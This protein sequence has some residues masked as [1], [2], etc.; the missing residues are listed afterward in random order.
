MQRTLWRGLC[1]VAALL[2]PLSVRALTPFPSVN[3]SLESYTAAQGYTPSVVVVIV[4]QDLA[5]RSIQGVN[6]PLSSGRAGLPK[7]TGTALFVNDGAWGASDWTCD[8]GKDSVRCSGAT[9]LAAGKKTCIALYL[10]GDFVPAAGISVGFLDGG[11][12]LL[13]TAGAE[14]QSNSTTLPGEVPASDRL[15]DAGASRPGSIS[16]PWLGGGILLA[17]GGVGFA[18]WSK[19]R[20]RRPQ[21][22]AFGVAIASVGA[23][24]FVYSF[25][26]QLL[27]FSWSCPLNCSPGSQQCRISYAVT[28]GTNSISTEQKNAEQ[29]ADMIESL[30]LLEL[31]FNAMDALDIAS[32]KSLKEALAELATALLG[33]PD[34]PA[35]A[36]GGSPLLGEVID[37]DKLK[38]FSKFLNQ[39]IVETEQ[40][41]NGIQIFAHYQ[42]D[43][44][45]MT[46]CWVV[47]NQTNWY[48]KRSWFAPLSPENVPSYRHPNFGT[49]KSQ[50]V[51]LWTPAVL[52]ASTAGN[53]GAVAKEIARQTTANMPPVC[54][55]IFQAQ[56]E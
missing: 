48:G 4:P 37:T 49:Y 23:L 18:L 28:T 26:P 17:V 34:T 9:S 21:H 12:N 55:A 42:V 24:L 36:Y 33:I 11:G 50:G 25:T 7:P 14:G 32:A 15:S 54:Q 27:F 31:P 29:T 38:Q 1:L 51:Y 13:F 19:Q 53:A 40:A 8:V 39:T 56:F 2:M 6:I 22:P 46:S 41:V 45:E 35:E 10:S 52:G 3:V 44:C 30:G 20:D 47:S 5:G 43:E 16:W